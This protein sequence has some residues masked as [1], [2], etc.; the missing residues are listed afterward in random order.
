MTNTPFKFFTITIAISLLLCFHSKAV[1]QWL[2]E[3]ISFT[4]TVSY[5]NPFLECTLDVEFNGPGG[6]Y[7]KRPAFWDGGD[8]WR[9]RFAPVSVG[10]WNYT[11]TCSDPSNTGLHSQTGSVS[12]TEYTGD[13]EI[14]KHGFLKISP[15]YRYFTYDDGTPF[16][17]LGDTHWFIEQ[18]KFSECNIPECESQFKYMVDRRIDQGYTVYQIHPY[19]LNAVN[20][21]VTEIDP[22]G[23]Q[24]VDKYYDYLAEKGLVISFGLGCHSNIYW[25]YTNQLNDPQGVVR[26][27]R[28][29]NARYGA[30][31]VVFFTS[32]E[33]DLDQDACANGDDGDW[34][35][36]WKLAFDEWALVDYYDHPLTNHLCCTTT[37]MPAC[38][39]WEEDPNHDLFFLQSGHY[40]SGVRTKS[41]FKEYWDYTTTKP[42]LESE[43]MYEQITDQTTPFYVRVVAYKAMQCGSAGFGYGSEGIWNNC[44]TD[45]DC[46]CCDA[47]IPFAWSEA[48][49]FPGGQQMQY[50]ANI[51]NITKWWELTPRFDDNTWAS[52]SN[53]EESVISSNNNNTYVVYFYNDNPNTGTLKNMNNSS[54]YTGRW[55]NPRTGYCTTIS[56]N[57]TPSSGSWSIPQ[58]PSSQD[59]LLIVTDDADIIDDTEDL[60]CGDGFISR[61]R[62][63]Q[64]AADDAGINNG[65]LSGSPAFSDTDNKEG[66]YAIVFDGSDDH[67]SVSDNSSLTGMDQLSV[68]FWIKLNSLPP[69]GFHYAPVAKEGSYRFVVSED[70]NTHFVF[71]TQN[72]AWYS[73]GTII[74]AGQMQ[75]GVWYHFTGIYDG[76]YL[77]TYMNGELHTTGDIALS[78]QIFD[79]STALTFGM[80]TSSNIVLFNGLLDDVRI[81]DYVLSIN[82]IQCMNNPLHLLPE[83]AGAITGESTVCQGDDQVVYTVP[84]IQ[85]AYSYEWTLPT[86]VTGTSTTNSITVSYGLSSV[87]GDITVKGINLYGEGAASSLAVTVNEKPATP[88]ITQDGYTLHS[89]A[90]TG[91]QWYDQNGLIPGATDQDYIVT[92]DGGYYVIVT[93]AGCSS[94]P[95][96][97]INV[98]ITGLET[99]DKDKMI[100][101][102]PNPVSKDLV[103]E[104]EGNNEKMN[105]EIINTS[106]K[107]VYKDGFL[108]KTNIQ[109]SNFPPGIYVIKFD[110]GKVITFKK[111][112]K[113]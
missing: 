13:Q 105:F 28:Y 8:T 75:T 11:T 42:L 87:S 74:S 32:Q 110:N 16:F 10:I 9:V 89:G 29:V 112:I 96:N 71:A 19:Y 49:N 3:E 38:M 37:D 39:V 67:V 66:S 73:E 111:I 46:S 72:N 43:A 4:S 86:G 35:P 2:I 24:D 94:D 78:G 92:S 63:E 83:D 59:W 25:T 22:T 82:D 18:E 107:V 26:L 21:G 113:D 54:V 12:C 76:Q 52:F 93:I 5:T 23:F 90:P 27:T 33:V 60:L 51:Y 36:Y 57:I 41:H 97:V 106:G 88:V 79:S 34:V 91:N 55:F 6:E 64:N 81:H 30:Y 103:I 99:A 101:V 70:G 98:Y 100:V 7:I 85:Y 20:A 84:S 65:S 69:S 68:S 1:E 61:W 50:L 95:S 109:I 17:Y 56:E 14:Y 44:Y 108:E 104:S 58:K 53:A 15:D 48:I 31:P 62:F 40:W 47:S 80:N 77:H 102:Y 45:A